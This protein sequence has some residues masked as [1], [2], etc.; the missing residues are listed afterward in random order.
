MLIFTDIP[1]CHL[2]PRNNNYKLPAEKNICAQMK[3]CC[4]FWQ[5]LNVGGFFFCFG[6]VLFFPGKSGQLCCLFCHCCLSDP[7][8]GLTLRRFQEDP[9]APFHTCP[10]P[11]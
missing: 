10:A 6:L 9:L 1:H 4:L 3:I 7:K 11:A 8:A 2:L 5:L